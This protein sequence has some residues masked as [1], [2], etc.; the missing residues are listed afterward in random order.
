MDAYDAHP[1]VIGRGI[2]NGIPY[3]DLQ[4]RNGLIR[5]AYC[6]E[7]IRQRYEDREPVRRAV[8]NVP[9]EVSWLQA[10]LVHRQCME[11]SQA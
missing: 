9:W 6:Y 4:F 10:D 3:T 8:C 11:S 2:S 7:A 5:R 1:V